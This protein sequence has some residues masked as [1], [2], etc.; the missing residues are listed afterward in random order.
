M[1]REI[2]LED[3]SPHLFRASPLQSGFHLVAAVFARTA[4]RRAAPMIGF[5]DF[6]TWF[7]HVDTPQN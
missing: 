5:F 7:G 3:A 4:A 6:A 2:G 1:S